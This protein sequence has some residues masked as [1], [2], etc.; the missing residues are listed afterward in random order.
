MLKDLD[1]DLERV[2]RLQLIEAQSR[3]QGVR[4][5]LVPDLIVREDQVRRVVLAPRGE[6]LVE[7]EIVPPRHRHQIPKPLM[8]ELVGDDDADPLLLLPRC[9]LFSCVRWFRCDL[10][11]RSK[12]QKG[13]NSKGLYSR[14]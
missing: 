8:G 6:A 9:R 10:H 13:S 4:S 14:K 1:R 11:S 7:L 2:R 5:E 12:C 3:R